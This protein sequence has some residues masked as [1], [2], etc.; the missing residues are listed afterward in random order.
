MV[1]RSPSEAISWSGDLTGPS[2]T[3]LGAMRPSV[4]DSLFT[5]VAQRSRTS[6]QLTQG[7]VTSRASRGTALIKQR[8]GVMGTP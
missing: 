4:T 3:P 7:A 8:G 1:G 6:R 2:G 5:G